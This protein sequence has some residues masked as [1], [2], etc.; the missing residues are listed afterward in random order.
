MRSNRRPECVCLLPTLDGQALCPS[1][2]DTVLRTGA[3]TVNVSRL[4]THLRKDTSLFIYGMPCAFQPP[5]A[6]TTR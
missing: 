6:K 5:G 4:T 1:V 2:P 3:L